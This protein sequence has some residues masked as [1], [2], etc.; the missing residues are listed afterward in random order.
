LKKLKISISTCEENLENAKNFNTLNCQF[1][2]LKLENLNLKTQNVALRQNLQKLT[3]S[4]N[5]KKSPKSELLEFL[6]FT[7]AQREITALKRL[8]GK[9]DPEYFKEKQKLVQFL[10]QEFS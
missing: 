3:I 10:N 4:E 2:N 1:E 6:N 5:S 7:A 9:G 8:E